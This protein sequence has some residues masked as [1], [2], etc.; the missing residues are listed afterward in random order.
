MYGPV[1]SFYFTLTFMPT[2]KNS[3]I[4][5]FCNHAT[6]QPLQPNFVNR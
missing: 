3:C 5:Y 6:L 1:L 4:G 2:E